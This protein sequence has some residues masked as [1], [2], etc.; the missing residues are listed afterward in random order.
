MSTTVT[1]PIV[2]T[3][4]R[5][6]IEAEVGRRANNKKKLKANPDAKKAKAKG[7]TLPALAGEQIEA[8]L[9]GDTVTVNFKSSRVEH[10]S[11]V[12]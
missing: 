6:A 2:K 5:Q 1:E 8:L 4:T 10:V 11:I 9:R 7:H 12:G 3:F